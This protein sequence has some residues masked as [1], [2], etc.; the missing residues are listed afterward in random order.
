M[1]I[2]K[3]IRV[4]RYVHPEFGD[5]GRFMPTGWT[6]HQD[7]ITM[8]HVMDVVLSFGWEAY[9]IH[10][11]IICHPACTETVQDIVRKRLL[12][13]YKNRESLMEALFSNWGE[14]PYKNDDPF[15]IRSGNPSSEISEEEFM[16]GR[17]MKF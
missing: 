10:D 7:A 4:P 17:P 1:W 5:F 16:N 11:A 2:S 3:E 6:H 13:I 9:S 12:F 8:D 15:G 14:N